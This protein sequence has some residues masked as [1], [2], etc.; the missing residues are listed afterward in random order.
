MVMTHVNHRMA[1]WLAG[2]LEPTE[3]EDFERHLDACPDCA[4]EA[5][6][7][8]RVWDL[9]DVLPTSAEARPSV[10]TAVKARTV[11]NGRSD[12]DWFF[13]VG[14]WTRRGWAAC[15]VAAGL[16][17]GMLLPGM[18]TDGTAGADPVDPRLA[19]S[20]WQVDGESTDLAEW[21]LAANYDEEGGS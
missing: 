9:V 1:A 17:M 6:Q 10:W 15:A 4:R 11:G 21:W 18:W 19:E 7:A 2:E 5:E 20:S 8:R 12:R 3:L 14:P 16:A 13:G